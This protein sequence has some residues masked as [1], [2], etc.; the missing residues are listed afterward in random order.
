MQDFKVLYDEDKDILYLAK[1]GQEEEI[2]EIAPGINLELDKHGKLIGVELFNA[3]HLL[4]DIIPP[5]QRKI[6]AA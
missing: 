4:K 2:V 1:Q 5:M 3:S 6:C